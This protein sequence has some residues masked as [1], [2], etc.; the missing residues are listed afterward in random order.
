MKIALSAK[1]IFFVVL[2]VS[3]FVVLSVLPTTASAATCSFTRDLEFG[4]TGEDV[5]C[6]QKYLNESGHTIAQSGAG[7]PGME[8]GEF[9]T[10]T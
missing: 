6:L 9:K 4:D 8:T 7:S 2:G 5:R 1:N 10:L 3:L